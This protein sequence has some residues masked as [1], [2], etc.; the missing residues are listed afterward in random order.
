MDGVQLCQDYR[1]NKR[2]QFTCYKS[3]TNSSCYLFNQ[4]RKDER[5]WFTLEPPSTFQP[6]PLVLGNQHPNHY[7]N[8]EEVC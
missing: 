4:S 6:G 2:R 7:D 5:M 8:W 1:V 3:V